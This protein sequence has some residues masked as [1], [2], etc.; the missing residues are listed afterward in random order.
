MKLVKSF[1]KYAG[2]YV[3]ALPGLIFFAV[4]SFY[5]MYSH[6]LAFKNFK[7]NLGIWGS[8][9]AGFDNFKFFFSGGKWINITANTLFLNA[10]FITF[11]M[12]VS[13]ALAIFIE[14]VSKKLLKRFLQSAVFLPYFV[15]WLVVN[16][17]VM[18]MLS[19]TSGIINNIMR[20]LGNDV[21]PF[22]TTPG[23][24]P[25]I[26]TALY[27]WKFAG[28]YSIIF[29]SV[30]TSI[31]V[32]LYESAK[33]DGANR[34]QQIWYITLPMLLGTVTILMFLS[35]GRIFYG[36]FGMIYGIIGDN[37]SLLKTT[38]VIDTFVFRAL[39]FMGNFSMAAAVALFQ[40]VMGMITVVTFNILTKKI[41]PEYRIF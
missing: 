38:E 4:F 17:L 33:I 3:L 35:I 39:R 31:P 27:I 32:D 16:L 29:L 18:T 24:W 12:I 36:D 5:P 13:L 20:Q 21:I 1:R 34:V 7:P 25:G 2:L 14:D 40:S 26:L 10:L 19:Q 23:M 6:L 8:P 22:Y 11:N 9:W 30:I 41:N 28:Y 37:G 15:S